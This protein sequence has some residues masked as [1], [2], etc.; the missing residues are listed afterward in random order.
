[1]MA[2]EPFGVRGGQRQPA[3]PLPSD[4]VTTYRSIVG[5]LLCLAVWTRMDLAF[6]VSSAAHRINQCTFGDIASVDKLVLRAQKNPEVGVR[7]RLGQSPVWN[8]KLIAYADNAYAN[9][10]GIKS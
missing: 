2:M 6:D 7:V 9:I 10:E 8:E 5:Q 4:L 3:D 1:M